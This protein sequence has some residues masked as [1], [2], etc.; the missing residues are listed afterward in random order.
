LLA[1]AG[2]GEDLHLQERAHAGRKEKN[3]P[4]PQLRAD[5]RLFCNRNQVRRRAGAESG[6]GL[7]A[8]GLLAFR[9]LGHFELDLLTFF[10]RLKAVHLDG[11]EVRE[12]ILATIVGRDETV[13]LGV[14]EPLYRTCWHKNIRKKLRGNPLLM[15]PW[16]NAASDQHPARRATPSISRFFTQFA[17]TSQVAAGPPGTDSGTAAQVSIAPRRDSDYDYIKAMRNFER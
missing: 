2:S 7:D 17:D 13:A 9:A 6:C 4:V 15:T 16:I 11:G 1:M 12:Q 8:R 14:V 5:C 3:R 10:E